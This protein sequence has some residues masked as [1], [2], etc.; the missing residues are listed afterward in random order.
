M[1]TGRINQV[2]NRSAVTRVPFVG[3]HVGLSCVAT[4]QHGLRTLRF[5]Y[6]QTTR[7]LVVG[8]NRPPLPAAV[9]YPT[10]NFCTL[11]PIPLRAVNF[12]TV[13]MIQALHDE[14]TR[15]L[16]VSRARRYRRRRG[17]SY[18]DAAGRC[19]TA[20]ISKQQQSYVSTN[21]TSNCCNCLLRSEIRHIPNA[22]KLSLFPTG[23]GPVKFRNL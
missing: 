17:R 15:S 3:D 2:A 19:T 12:E 13:D 21:R 8:C 16:N 18:V 10:T 5:A 1:T 11:S 6:G 20:A 4:K 22:H 23:F 14:P 7:Q 9:P